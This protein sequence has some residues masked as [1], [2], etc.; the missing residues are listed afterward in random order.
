KGDMT[1]SS[2]S[3]CYCGALRDAAETK[4]TIIAGEHIAHFALLSAGAN[5]SC[6]NRLTVHLNDATS[7][8]LAR[9]QY[10]PRNLRRGGFLN[11]HLSQPASRMCGMG[12][13]ECVR[14]SI[15]P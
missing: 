9:R 15:E 4:T 7:Q 12:D 10:N 5:A 6:S 14:T 8:F 11:G 13:C 2:D 1:T 3:D